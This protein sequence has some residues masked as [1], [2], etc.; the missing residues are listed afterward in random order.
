MLSPIGRSRAAWVAACAG[1]ALVYFTG[2]AGVG[3]VGPDEPRYAS[4]GRAMADA[5]DWVTPKLWGEA[6]F[7]KPALL[8][9]MIAL[10]H[11]AGLGPEWGPRLPVAILSMLF[12]WF[13]HS[14]LRREFGAPAAGFAAAVLAT[15]AG[16]IAFSQVAV[17]D[18]PMAAAFSAAML[19]ALRWIGTGSR[20]T[21]AAAGALLG[22]AVLAKGLVPLVLAAPLAWFGRRR[23][24]EILPG[25]GAFLVV[26]VPWYA[27]C[28]LRNG[29]VFFDQFFWRHH[30]ERF[31]SESLAHRQ[32]FWFYAPVLLAGLFPWTPLAAHL[33]GRGLLRGWRRQL[34]VVWVLFGFVFFSASTNKLPGYLLPLMPA[35][36][37]LMGIALAETRRPRW[38]L[39]ACGLL[40]GLIPVVAAALPDLLIAGL[41]RADLGAPGWVWIAMA[42]PV[43]FLERRGRRL[44][45]VALVAAG[46]GA[47]ILWIKLAALPGADARMTARP[48][49]RAV[50]PRAG[51]VCVEPIHRAWRYGLNYYSREPLP[52]CAVAPRP[53]RIRQRPGNMPA[54]ERGAEVNSP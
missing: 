31:G 7:E 24:R 16:W 15:S 54:I 50:A 9:W 39:A 20:R 53:L 11:R 49:W 25:A 29:Q 17:T 2:L 19:L 4:I 40:L 26:A 23:V 37:A 13:Y 42:V 41:R 12:L 44:A 27:L 47:G 46:V 5:G 38:S 21:L 33:F 10:G 48:L 18:L 3:L 6:W 36:C 34:L 45:A 35:L 28:W 30:F 51:E 52:D 43:W 14:A 8:Y 22:V 1:L 32:P